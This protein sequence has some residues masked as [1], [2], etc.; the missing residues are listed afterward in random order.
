[1]GQLFI[2]DESY[3][4]LPQIDGGLNPA[5]N[6]PISNKAVSNALAEVLKFKK[7][8]TYSGTVE[9]TLPTIFNEIIIVGIGNSV[10]FTGHLYYAQLI[11][12]PANYQFGAGAIGG[13][14]NGI[15]IRANYK[16][17]KINWC[18]ETGADCTSTF[19][20]NIFYR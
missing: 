3:G 6:N 14:W 9:V 17:L 16:K 20:Y 15:E 13:S 7:L 5:S 4:G 11:G 18:Y 8:G 12:A 2:N 19:N 1:M 10:Y